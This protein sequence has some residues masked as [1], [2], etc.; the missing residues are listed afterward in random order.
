MRSLIFEVVVSF[1][2]DEAPELCADV[3]GAFDLTFGRSEIRAPEAEGGNLVGPAGLRSRD[4]A[5]DAAS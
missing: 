3:L 5:G 4:G 1:W 2:G